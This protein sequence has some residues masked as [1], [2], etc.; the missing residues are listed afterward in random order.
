MKNYIPDRVA[1]MSE[2]VPDT[3]CPSVKL[4]ANESPYPM[5]EDAKKVADLLK[6]AFPETECVTLDLGAAFVTQGGP[7]C[8]AIQYIEKRK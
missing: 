5:P 6:E 7:G 4:D 2:Y 3:S 1:K 8:V